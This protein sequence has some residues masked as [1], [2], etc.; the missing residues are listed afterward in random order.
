MSAVIPGTDSFPAS[1]IAVAEAGILS[2]SHFEINVYSNQLSQATPAGLKRY[3]Y[4]YILAIRTIPQSSD[5]KNIMNRNIRE[6]SELS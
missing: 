1:W 2:V 5:N 3:L 6:V 4:K